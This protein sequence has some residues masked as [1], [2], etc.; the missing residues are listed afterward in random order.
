MKIFLSNFSVDLRFKSVDR[1]CLS[2]STRSFSP[3]VVPNSH[4]WCYM[5]GLRQIEINGKK[6]SFCQLSRW[7]IDTG[8]TLLTFTKLKQDGGG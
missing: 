7:L 3:S 1:Y 2:T 5:V 6:F 8:Y 4:D